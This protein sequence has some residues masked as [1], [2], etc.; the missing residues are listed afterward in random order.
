[1]F[2]GKEEARYGEKKDE[3][4]KWANRRHAH[5]TGWYEGYEPETERLIVIIRGGAGGVVRLL[6]SSVTL[7]RCQ[8]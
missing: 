2:H 8:A 1:M 3:V 7:Y 5:W 4:K 6:R